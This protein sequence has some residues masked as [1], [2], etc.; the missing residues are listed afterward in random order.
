MRIFIVIIIRINT[1]ILPPI[2]GY[3]F[4][5]DSNFSYKGQCG[6]GSGEDKVNDADQMDQEMGSFILLIF[7]KKEIIWSIIQVIWI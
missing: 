7:P 4:S 3:Q 1:S 5:G 6:G 2:N